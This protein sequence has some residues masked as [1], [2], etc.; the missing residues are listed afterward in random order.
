MRRRGWRWRLPPEDFA[1]TLLLS[2]DASKPDALAVIDVKPGSPSYSQVVHTV[3]M[4]YTGR[5]V[6]PFRLECMLLVLVAAHR[7]RVSRAAL[8]DHPRHPLVAHL[9]RGHEAASD[10]GEDPQD[11]RAGGD[12]SERPAIHG[13]IRCIA[14]R[15]ASTSARS[16]AAARTAPR[17][18]RASSSWTARRSRSWAVGRSTADRRPSTM[19]SGGTCRATTWCRA[20]GACRRSSRTASSPEDLLAEQVRPSRPLLGSAR[21]AQCADDR[22]RRQSPDGAGNTPGA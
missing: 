12:L 18:R 20:N 11:H 15:R 4:P 14:G 17:V 16:A 22:P 3:T 7:P 9:R 8:S 1:Y 5:R 19:I 10:P 13:R 6:S 21:P 2:P